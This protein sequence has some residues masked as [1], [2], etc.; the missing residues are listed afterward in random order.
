MIAQM[1]S[2]SKIYH[3]PGCRFINRIEEKSLVSFDL[4]DGRIKYLKPC[5]C[6]CNIKFVYNGYRENLNDVFRDL[7]IWTELR[8]DY[9]G[10]HTDWYNWR[11]SLSKSSQD[12]RLYLEEWNEELQKDLLIRV[13]EIGKS[14]NLKT[15]MRY[16]VKEERVAFYPCKYRKYA[17]GIEYL[18]NKRGVQIE[19][20]DTDLYILTDMAA[21]KISYVQY[22]D[23]YK[24]LH[25]PFDGKPLTMEEAKTAH[26]HV[27]RDVAKNQ[28]P[29]NHLEY[30]L[31]HDEAKKLMQVSYKKLPKV[32]KQ[33]KKY[34]RQAENR[35]KRNSIRRVW[36]LFAE[37]ESGKEKY[38]SRF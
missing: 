20:D 25:C 16:I 4:D 36:K 34:Y 28:S 27:Q 2:K 3:R 23:R 22:F 24:L 14:K 21:W 29:Y 32:T 30:I 8:E 11:I 38:G 31:R 7:P 33:Q 17:L 9:I 15:A 19:F 13:D 1:S 10:V 18:A 26:Y 6:C 5:K 35:E 37:L 12:I